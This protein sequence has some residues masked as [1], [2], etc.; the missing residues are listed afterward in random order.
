MKVD[1]A[2]Y[3]AAQAV[4]LWRLGIIIPLRKE[5]GPYRALIYELIIVASEFAQELPE[6][7]ATYLEEIWSIIGAWPRF[8][9][10][11][12]TVEAYEERVSHA[13]KL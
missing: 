12:K 11:R 10:L 1:A 7:R 13:R 8:D 4:M 9:P 6:I 5:Y 2:P 3:L